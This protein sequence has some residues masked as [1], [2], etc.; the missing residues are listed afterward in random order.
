MIQWLLPIWSLVPLPFLNPAWTSGSSWFM[1]YWSLAWRIFSITLLVC[2]MSAIVWSF[3]HSFA[4][5]FFGIEMKT[6]LFQS[7]GHCWVFQIC[8]HIECSIFM[9]SSFR[10]WNSSARNPSPA[11]ALFVVMLPKAH[12]TSHSRMSGSR[13]VI[14]PSWLSGS[15][16]PFFCTILLCILA[17][18]S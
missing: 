6:D 14:T 17:I 4:L 11:L 12:L 16:R 7:C 13:W 1:Y 10:I 5:S 9:A 8:W 15:W 3:E 18:S 2:V